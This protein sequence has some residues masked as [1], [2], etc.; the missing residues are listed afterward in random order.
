MELGLRGSMLR[1]KGQ[2]LILRQI[3]EIRQGK[4][5]AD[6][7]LANRLWVGAVRLKTMA[8]RAKEPTLRFK[9]LFAP[10]A[11]ELTQLLHQ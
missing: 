1:M 10:S 8:M 2:L 11:N 9:F 7:L 3:R 6:S 4:K 5:K